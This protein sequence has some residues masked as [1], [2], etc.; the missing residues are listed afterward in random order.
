M[1]DGG[2]VPD[3]LEP[4]SQCEWTPPI[5]LPYGRRSAPVPVNPSAVV[6]ELE[7]ALQL[8]HPGYPQ[9]CVHILSGV[10]DLLHS[11]APEAS[12]TIDGGEG[13]GSHGCFR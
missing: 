11:I 2:Y 6:G 12:H 4:P 5:L 3:N 9:P 8:F 13:T 7:H 1:N 10:G